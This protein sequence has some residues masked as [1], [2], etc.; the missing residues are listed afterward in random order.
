[1][2]QP[3]EILNDIPSDIHNLAEYLE[4]S[5]T[6][7]ADKP[8]FT[9]LGK[10]LTFSEIDE[11]SKALAAWLQNHSG[12]Q[13]GDR[14]AIQLP[15]LTQYPI[16]AYAVLRAGFIIVNTNPL[17]TSPEMLHQFNDSGAKAII[18]LQDL[19]PKL[20]AIQAKTGIEKVI[21]TGADD[22]IT[23]ETKLL[24]EG[25]IGLMQTIDDGRK[26]TLKPS[27][28]Q[29]NDIAVLQ[30]TGGTTGVSKGAALTH[31]NLI[32]NT[33]QTNVRFR[34]VCNRGE[35]TIICPLPL[36]HLYA[37]MVNMILFASEGQHNVL[38]ANP[39]DLDSFVTAIK[40][41]PPSAFIGLNTLFVALC[42][43]PPFRDLDFSRLKLTTSGG[44]SLTSATADLWA[45]TTGCTISE[46]Y[47]LSE[48]GPILTFNQP[49][50]E[51]LGSV[52]HPVVGTEIQLW[53]DKDQAVPDGEE[54]QVVARGPQ[55]MQGYWNK[56][57]ETAKVID[58]DG[59][60]KTG[61]VG[62]RLPTGQI[63]IVDRL[64]DLIIVSG[65]NVYPNE[66]EDVLTRHPSILEA[67]VVGEPDE[68][69]GERVCAF[70]TVLNAVDTDEVLA[71][72]KENL[73]GYKI[74]KQITVLEE[75]P[76]STVGKILRRELRI[77]S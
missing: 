17:Y 55:I 9:S 75:L 72:C 60:F 46:G 77:K 73:T 21:V 62:I 29:L 31:R 52:G 25:Q 70:I 68:K 61:D 14:I 56:P 35:E 1:M 53:N 71:Y 51:L 33:Q 48:T 6:E 64:K 58:K 45:K 12:L 44:T 15:N 65:F 8:A 26:E 3:A 66:V 43:H 18:I 23:G 28:A 22:L 24:A 38:I 76:K 57:E 40:Q 49:R 5:L 37:F 50:H 47:G 63:K 7:F 10:T 20:E 34:M 32:A 11:Y 36:Y 39:R 19:Y 2:S 67:A 69:S 16:A 54:G 13:P 42:N 41:F 4:C 74:P 27:T 59:W 30:Y